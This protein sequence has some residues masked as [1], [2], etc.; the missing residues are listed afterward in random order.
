VLD[1]LPDARDRPGLA[2]LRVVGIGS[3]ERGDDAAGLLAARFLRMRVPD[4]VAV[5]CCSADPVSL[6]EAWAGAD[7]VWLTDAVMSG[8]PAGT[9]HRI[10]VASQALLPRPRCRS[11]HGLGLAEAVE[12][13]RTL[14]RLPRSLVIFGIEAA[15][16]PIGGLPSA[17]VRAGARQAAA[18]IMGEVEAETASAPRG[19]DDHRPLEPGR[20][21]H[22]SVP[23]R[24]DLER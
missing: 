22:H 2:A 7:R 11:T 20:F 15:S 1:P 10:D 9:V 24:F 16:F 18:A 17:A 23:D 3:A 21:G 4:G 19:A 13:G 5:V 12:L 8:A 6:F 14:G